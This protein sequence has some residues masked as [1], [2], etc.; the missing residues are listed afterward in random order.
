MISPDEILDILLLIRRTR[1]VLQVARQKELLKHGITPEHA[2]VLHILSDLGGSA[3]PMDISLWLFR[4]R[5]S[6][7]DLLD[8]MEKA[9]LIRKTN[10]PRRKNGILVVLTGQGRLLYKES[11]KLSLPAKIIS[12]LSKQERK[13]LKKA[14]ERLLTAGQKE[15]SIEDKLP[16][17]PPTV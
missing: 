10:D 9:G 8:R 3:R 7:H 12:S 1:D 6:A 5:Q 14:L 15:T 17:R 13:Q 4:K 2:A 16:L 11:S